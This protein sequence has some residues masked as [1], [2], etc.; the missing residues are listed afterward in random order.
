MSFNLTEKI[1]WISVKDKTQCIRGS[2]GGLGGSD[3]PGK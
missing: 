2:R 3:T 1:Y